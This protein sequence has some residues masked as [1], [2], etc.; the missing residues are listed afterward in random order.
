MGFSLLECRSGG[1]VGEKSRLL[2]LCAPAL[3]GCEQ[4]AKELEM[5]RSSSVYRLELNSISK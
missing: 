1:A 4:E 3:G 2:A 5:E